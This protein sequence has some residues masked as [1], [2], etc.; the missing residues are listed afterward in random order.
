MESG[1]ELDLSPVLNRVLV[2]RVCLSDIRM[3]EAPNYRYLA[4]DLLLEKRIHT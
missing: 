1:P 3:D 4:L 2:M